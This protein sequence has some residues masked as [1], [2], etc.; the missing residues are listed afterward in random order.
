[1]KQKRKKES[2]FFMMNF[3]LP[4]CTETKMDF[5]QR[6]ILLFIF[7]HKSYVVSDLKLAQRKI[8]ALPLASAI[9]PVLFLLKGFIMKLW[10]HISLMELLL[11]LSLYHLSWAEKNNDLK[12]H[13]CKY[14]FW[15]QWQLNL[16]ALC[17]VRDDYFGAGSVP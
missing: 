8:L 10:I 7:F 3:N 15:Q 14:L 2:E 17:P 13:F 16:P 11:L 5:I 12:T 4:F 9:L 1:M 6:Q